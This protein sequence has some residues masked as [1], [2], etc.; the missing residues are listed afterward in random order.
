MMSK[1]II[2]LLLTKYVGSVLV[3]CP[4]K[5]NSTIQNVIVGKPFHY[6][7]SYRLNKNTVVRTKVRESVF[8]LDSLSVKDLESLV[9][10]KCSVY[11]RRNVLM[12]SI[13]VVEQVKKVEEKVVNDKIRGLIEIFGSITFTIIFF[14]VVKIFIIWYKK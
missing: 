1:F 11:V 5:T 2:M 6:E 3:E 12:S 4:L 14:Y 13:V 9:Y 7:W 8:D 10:L